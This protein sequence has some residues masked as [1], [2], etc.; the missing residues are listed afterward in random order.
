MELGF[1]MVQN[2]GR[3]MCPLRNIKNYY[4]V[5][6]GGLCRVGLPEMFLLVEVWVNGCSKT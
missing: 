5:F 2:L 3:Y 1:T 4:A 6:R